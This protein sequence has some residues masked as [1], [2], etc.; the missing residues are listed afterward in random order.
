MSKLAALDLRFNKT[1]S[2]LFSSAACAFSSGDLKISLVPL[3]MRLFSQLSDSPSSE[4][5][6]L[7]E[8]LMPPAVF[9]PL[10]GTAFPVFLLFFDRLSVSDS[11]MSM[12][13]AAVFASGFP[14]L[15][16]W[17]P[18]AFFSNSSKS[19]S[20]CAETPAV[21]A[22]SPAVKSAKNV[23]YL[24]LNIFIYPFLP[25]YQG[26]FKNHLIFG[27]YKPENSIYN[28]SVIRL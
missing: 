16:F 13:A 15:A 24:F 19:I 5:L 22:T 1:R 27:I 8:S 2:I 9:L 18:S 28:L 7:P 12:S 25:L 4:D 23:K 26:F 10:S 3:L 11:L 14:R 21:P 17:V 20:D 6:P